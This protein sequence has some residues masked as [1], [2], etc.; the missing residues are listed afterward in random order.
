MIILYAEHVNTPAPHDFTTASSPLIKWLNDN[1][2]PHVTAIV[3]STFSELMESQMATGPIY[4][5]VKD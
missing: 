5:Y 4:D 1:H 3:T 2:H